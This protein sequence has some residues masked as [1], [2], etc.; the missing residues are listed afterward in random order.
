[1]AKTQAQEQG[2]KPGAGAV[3]QLSPEDELMVGEY[4]QEHGI[5]RADALRKLLFFAS[6][7]K[8]QAP[9]PKPTLL[10]KSMQV[11]QDAKEIGMA[12]TDPND[13][14][15]VM[16][17]SVAIQT[18]GEQL[19]G[20]GKGGRGEKVSIEDIKELMYLKIMGN[21]A[22]G[23]GDNSSVI[24]EIKAENEKQRQFY[25]NKLK[26]QD[27]KIKEM[28]FEKKIQTMQETNEQALAGI[29]QQLQ[30]LSATVTLYK[31]VPPNATPQEKQDAISRLKSASN[32][33]KSIKDA[34]TELG[35]IPQT[36]TSTTSPGTPGQ[37]IWRN[38]DGSTNK[39]MYF[40]DRITGAGERALD[41]WQKKTPEFEK[42]EEPAHQAG[43]GASTSP[44]K[45]RITITDEIT[46]EDYFALLIAKPS[47]SPDEQQWLNA[48]AYRFVPKPASRTSAQ[49]QPAPEPKPS[50]VG[51]LPCRK[52]GGPD[53]IRNGLC[54]KCLDETSVP[55]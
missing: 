46:P 35:L 40:L 44:D 25:E 9:A 27:E 5:P 10:T 7:A 32:E 52:C 20:G 42:I 45:L 33:I 47:L 1:M 13:A 37:E 29:G 2:S 22:G 43:A 31:N 51:I 55:Q 28:I 18:L 36:S 15:N 54:S 34:L 17:R 26:E 53:V 8:E 48:N 38:K 39:M 16:G 50:E 14:L 4:A 41:A 12:G 24:Q 30:D 19:L 49:I 23:S 21:M 11:I 3:I 6:A